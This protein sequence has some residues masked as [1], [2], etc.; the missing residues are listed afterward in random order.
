MA[1]IYGENGSGKTNLMNAVQFILRTLDTIT[2]I[3]YIKMNDDLLKSLKDSQ[4]DENVN[5]ILNR[6]IRGNLKSLEQL[7]SENRTIACSENLSLTIGFYLNGKEGSYSAEFDDRGIISEILKYQINNRTGV[8][9]SIVN[10]KAKFSSS[11][12]SKKEYREE[13]EDL[14]EKYWG[15]HTFLSIVSSEFELKNTDFMN[16]N[17]GPSFLTFFNWING[18]WL[19]C[20]GNRRGVQRTGPDRSLYLK[21]LDSGVIASNRANMLIS[22]ETALDVFFT[23]LYSDIKRVYY[24]TENMG[25]KVKYSLY[26]KKIIND[27][28]VEI[29]FE[30]ESSGT[31]KLLDLFPF[32]LSA[33]SGNTI[34]MDEIDNG[35]HDIMIKEIVSVLDSAAEEDH[36]GQ[37]IAT[38]HNTLLMD[39]LPRDSVYI[40]NCDVHGNRK[41]TP[42]DKY[43]FRT[44]PN[45]SVRSKYLGGSYSGI[46]IVGY[47]DLNEITEN[48]NQS[49][50]SLIHEDEK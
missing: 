28:E 10:G 30:Q 44:H 48:Y 12:F 37:F 1:F 24:K 18:I 35:I 36:F 14:I 41:I 3:E 5:N 39:N 38:T 23:R 26:A 50:Y 29:P 32:F 13:L 21:Q 7:I 33:V 19:S 34:A 9:F 22:T 11:V 47:L 2:N 16:E 27:Q 42:I 46:P 40:L 6:V 17:I 43:D 15:K 45:N 8:L 49:L 25:D 31:N 20:K 4:D